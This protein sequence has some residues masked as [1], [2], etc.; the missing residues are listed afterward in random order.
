MAPRCWRRNSTRVKTIRQVFLFGFCAAS[1]NGQATNTQKLEQEPWCAGMLA[2]GR[3]VW[4][5]GGRR[6]PILGGSYQTSMFGK[7]P[8]PPTP[9][10]PST[11]CRWPWKIQG[12]RRSF[13]CVT[14]CWCG[15]CGRSGIDP[16][17]R[18]RDPWGR[19]AGSPC[20]DC[21][22][23]GCFCQAPRDGFTACPVRGCPTA[24]L[25]AATETPLF[26]LRFP[27]EATK[28]KPRPKSGLFVLQLASPRGFEPRSPP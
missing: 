26:A 15:T 12:R 1:A 18:A 2:W 8:V 6:E 28:K 20:R 25:L 17:F 3:R 24:S 14:G 16:T 21:Q 23:H 11:V 9:A 27:L 10:D 19:R 5:Y 22:K 4:G 13:S 7:A